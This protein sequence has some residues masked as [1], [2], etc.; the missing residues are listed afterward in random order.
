MKKIRIPREKW[1]SLK[2][3]RLTEDYE[4]GSDGSVTIIA[5][6]EPRGFLTR[7]LRLVS[8]VPPPSYKRFVLDRVGG[9]LWLLCDGSR[10]I[11]DLIKILMK[12]TGLSRRNVELAVYNYIN[13]LISKG[14]LALL[15]T[16]D[17]KD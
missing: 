3:L 5:R 16:E 15:A 4:V 9:K 14:L 7:F 13:I 11:D 8:I 10:T 12:E 6:V 2:P 1:L 17:K